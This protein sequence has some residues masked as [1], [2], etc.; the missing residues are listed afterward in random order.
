MSGSLN[1]IFIQNVFIKILFML[2]NLKGSNFF[3][4]FKI[5]NRVLK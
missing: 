2:S 5:E 3:P 1:T 4:K